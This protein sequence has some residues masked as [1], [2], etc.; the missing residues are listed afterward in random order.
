MTAD[1]INRL[2]LVS[3]LS[4]CLFVLFECYVLPFHTSKG[5]VVTKTEQALSRL[6]VVIFKIKTEK[7][8]ITVPSSAY[9][10]TN[11]NDT[12]EVGSSFITHTIQ[13]MAVYKKGDAYSWR[14]G[15][16]ALGGLDFLVLLIVSIS[17]Y[18]FFFYQKM[19]KEQI[20]KDIT[21]F[22][23]FLSAIFFLFY[24]LFE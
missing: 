2:I 9:K 8:L 10:N 24:F 3:L 12:I 1:Q 14:V 15:F 11:I 4:I 7:G 5:V 16:V 21:I 13:R 19:K 22:L 17:S 23:I 18:V 6:R 20:K